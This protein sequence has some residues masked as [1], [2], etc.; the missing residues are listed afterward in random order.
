MAAND[1]PP[2]AVLVRDIV[3]CRRLIDT[4]EANVNGDRNQYGDT[5]L[6]I[7]CLQGKE[8]LVKLYSSYYPEMNQFINFENN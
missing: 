1:Y 5:A 7:A 3:E 2:L 8:E 6:H 4:G